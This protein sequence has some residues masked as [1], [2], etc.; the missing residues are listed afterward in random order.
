MDLSGHYVYEH[1]KDGKCYYVGKGQRDRAFT[2]FRNNDGWS[3]VFSSPEEWYK[4]CIN[5]VKII[6]NF[7][8]EKDAIDFEMK[9]TDRRFEEGHP[10]VNRARG[11]AVI[12]TEEMKT[13]LR[14]KYREHGHPSKGTKLSKEAIKNISNAAKNRKYRKAVCKNCSKEYSTNVG[15]SFYCSKDCKLDALKKRRKGLIE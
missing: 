15:R 14:E 9:L 3:K 13:A 12:Y 2:Y 5:F 11:K 4:N 1:W 6:K 8:N 7:D 10:L